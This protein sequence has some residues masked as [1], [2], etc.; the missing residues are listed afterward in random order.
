MTVKGIMLWNSATWFRS[1]L[2][3]LALSV[4]V[5]VLVALVRE[6]YRRGKLERLSVLVSMP[7]MEVLAEAVQAVYFLLPPLGLV[8]LGWLSPAPIGISTELWLP[9]LF[10]GLA[11]ATPLLLALLAAVWSSRK[12][13]KLDVPK[14]SWAVGFRDAIYHQSHWAFYRAVWNAVGPGIYAATWIGVITV[15]AEWAMDPSSYRGESRRRIALRMAI[16]LSTAAVFLA[17]NS[18]WL[19]M[20]FHW[21]AEWASGGEW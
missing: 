13:M 1:P 20:A 15:L 4:A 16:L 3:W 12:Q 8:A 17:S 2:L 5:A 9:K 6:A 21:A 18:L 14:G 10:D 19:C 7:G 11:V